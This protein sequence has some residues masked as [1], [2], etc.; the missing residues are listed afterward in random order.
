MSSAGMP[1]VRLGTPPERWEYRLALVN[2]DGL[3][4][5]DV[6]VHEIEEYLNARGAE[7]WELVSVVDI[8]RG[9]G[10][11]TAL[12]AILKRPDRG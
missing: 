7:G 12:L 2:T 3:F 9:Q 8:T 11:T 1:T 6:N 10:T 4:G 5:P